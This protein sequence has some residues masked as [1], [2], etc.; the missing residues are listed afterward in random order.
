L[1]TQR[2]PTAKLVKLESILLLFWLWLRFEGTQGKG[3]RKVKMD[4]SFR[5]NDDG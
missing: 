4:S 2:F 1:E 3:N 5:W